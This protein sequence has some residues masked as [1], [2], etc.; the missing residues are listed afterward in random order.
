MSAVTMDIL[1]NERQTRQT[2]RQTETERERRE[3][4]SGRERTTDGQTEREAK[5][6]E[7]GGRMKNNVLCHDPDIVAT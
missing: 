6:G 3:G 5:G 2:N 7:R 1:W 4:E